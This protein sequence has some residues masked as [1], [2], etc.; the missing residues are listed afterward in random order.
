LTKGT[1]P[2]KLTLSAAT[3]VIYILAA[4]TDET[5]YSNS[6]TSI[7]TDIVITGISK[8][9]VFQASN[10]LTKLTGDSDGASITAAASGISTNDIDSTTVTAG[11]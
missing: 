1:N 6:L 4:K 3:S 11:T 10:K 2:S 5:V 7:D 9:E 8:V